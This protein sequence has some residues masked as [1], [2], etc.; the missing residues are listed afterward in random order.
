MVKE[1]LTKNLGAT[2]PNDNMFDIT[3]TCNANDTI[4]KKVKTAF[5]TAVQ[6]IS[7]TFILNSRISLN[8]SYVSFCNGVPN[9]P[10]SIVLG[11]AAPANWILMQDDDN[12]QRL[13]PQALVKQFQ[14]PTHPKYTDYDIFAMF[15]SD[16]AY[17]FTGDPPIRPDQYDFLYVMLHELFHGLGFGSSWEE[18]IPG[19]VTPM[20]AV[21][22]LKDAEFDLNSPDPQPNDKIRFYE[23]AFDKYM[24]F[25]NGTKTSGVTDELNKFF[26]GRSG[27]EADFDSNFGRSKQFLLARR[28]YLV[29]QTSRSLAY[30]LQESNDTLILETSFNPFRQGS[31]ISHVDQSTYIDTSDFLMGAQARNGTTISSLTLATGNFS[32][33]GP[34]LK[35]TME[36]MGYTSLDNPNPYRPSIIDPKTLISSSSNLLKPHYLKVDIGFIITIVTTLSLHILSK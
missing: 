7:S 6:M 10:N 27:T 22:P 25:K 8:A 17:W 13:Y 11:Q 5:D 14:F 20:P 23:W 21:N 35:K 33:I 32:G 24:I 29:S 9:C 30:M 12:A 1:S 28:M 26:S 19:V 4:C 31:S 3:L 36:T 2:K 34:K 16:I 15:N 18:Y